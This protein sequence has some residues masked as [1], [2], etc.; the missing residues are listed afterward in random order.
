V[1]KAVEIFLNPLPNAVFDQI[2]HFLIDL[3]YE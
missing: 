2:A 3:K 1:E